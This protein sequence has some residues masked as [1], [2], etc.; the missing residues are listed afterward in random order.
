MSNGLVM[1]IAQWVLELRRRSY[2][3]LLLFVRVEGAGG[4]GQGL[5]AAAQPARPIVAR[6]PTDCALRLWVRPG[7]RRRVRAG[8]PALWGIA[9]R[10]GREPAIKC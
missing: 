9:A 8:A 4:V 2:L 3:E 6:V 10:P 7:V 5:V 1:R